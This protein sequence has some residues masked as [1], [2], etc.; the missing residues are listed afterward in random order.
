MRAEGKG[1]RVVVACKNCRVLDL[2]V[3]DLVWMVTWNHLCCLC[4][5]QV[6]YL[7]SPPI[8]SSTLF[9]WRCEGHIEMPF[10]IC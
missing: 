10:H 7:S 2:C 8:S 5:H 4:H 9:G 6:I 3:A 1:G